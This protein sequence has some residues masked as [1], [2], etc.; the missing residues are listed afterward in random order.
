M[1]ALGVTNVAGIEIP[2]TSPVFLTIVG[3]HVLVGLVCVATGVTAMLSKKRPGRHP[4]VGTAYFWSLVAV[5]V[6]ATML[7][8]VRWVEDYHLFILGALALAAAYLGLRGT[9]PTLDRLDH[10]H[11][12]LLRSTFDH[13][14]RR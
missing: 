14:L 5:F 3:L 12:H 4:N 9:V 11:G 1:T 2:S 10:R 6:S 13:L 8:A 7:S